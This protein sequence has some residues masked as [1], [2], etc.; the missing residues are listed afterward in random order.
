MATKESVASVVEVKPSELLKQIEWTLGSALPVFIWGPPGIGKSQIVADL[1]KAMGIGFVDVRANLLAPQDIRGIPVADLQRQVVNWFPPGF[2]PREGD[3][4]IFLDELNTA[5][6]AVMASFLQFVLDRKVG[7]YTLPPGWRIIAAGNRSEDRALVHEM[8][9]PL[10]NRFV[11]FNLKPD[12]GDWCAWASAHGIAPSVI[13]F[14]RWRGSELLYQYDPGIYRQSFPTP[15]SWEHVSH[16]VSR[17]ASPVECPAL[18]SGIV[19]VGPA[20]EFAAFWEL[21]D[22]VP[23]AEKV[24]WENEDLDPPD[25]SHP[26]RLYAFTANLVSAATRAPKGKGLVVAKRLCAYS[27]SRLPAEY[28]AKVVNDF[29]QTAAYREIRADLLKSEEGRAC[30]KKYGAMLMD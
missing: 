1:A 29:V 24:L 5:P 22:K 23:S 25:E 6:P 10:K 4:I 17:G 20:A 27:V 12:V 2:L 28:G 15:R 13:G 8:P 3:G 19:G 11:H 21:A 7:E 26:D 16:L 14:M 18:F 30:T 9:S